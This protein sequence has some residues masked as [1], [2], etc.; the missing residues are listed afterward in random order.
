MLVQVVGSHAEL[1]IG[2]GVVR[3]FNAD[4]IH[5]LGLGKSI[6]SPWAM[7]YAATSLPSTLKKWRTRSLPVVV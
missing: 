6:R 3:Y 7:L 2:L 4:L 5:F 1:T